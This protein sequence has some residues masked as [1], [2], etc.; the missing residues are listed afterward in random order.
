MIN[1]IY[2]YKESPVSAN[3]QVLYRF[4]ATLLTIRRFKKITLSKLQVYLWGLKNE[5]NK[6][7][8]VNWKKE[9]RISNAPWLDDDD[10]AQIITQCICNHYVRV[11][12]NKSGKVS[13]KLDYA[14]TQLFREVGGSEIEKYITNDLD[15]I[16]GLTNKLLNN[17]VFDF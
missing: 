7:A 9:E 11:E 5:D 1:T 17:V 8:L 14:A 16:G 6:Q 12:Q 15:E 2:T 13:Y 3:E 4:L 10:T